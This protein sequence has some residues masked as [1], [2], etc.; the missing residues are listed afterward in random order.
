MN[1]KESMEKRKGSDTTNNKVINVHTRCTQSAKQ[2]QARRG[3]EGDVE[4]ERKRKKRRRCNYYKKS[5]TM[6]DRISACI[7]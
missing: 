1:R 6:N 4:E 2:K 3:C 7:S 5:S